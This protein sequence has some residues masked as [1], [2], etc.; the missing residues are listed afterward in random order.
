[1]KTAAASDW[2]GLGVKPS[3]M[4]RHGTR[5]CSRPGPRCCRPRIPR[6]RAA[7]PSPVWLQC[8]P[9]PRAKNP[10]GE[11][12]RSGEEGKGGEGKRRAGRETVGNELLQD[13]L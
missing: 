13:K 3:S 9:A 10:L 5:R 11:R 7:I 6:S 4:K 12:E 2:I 8:R 1:M